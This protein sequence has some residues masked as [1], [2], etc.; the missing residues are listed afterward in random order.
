MT[1]LEQAIT[2]RARNELDPCFDSIARRQFLAMKVRFFVFH[3]IN[4]GLDERK[5]PWFCTGGNCYFTFPHI[6]RCSYCWDKEFEELEK[7]GEP[8]L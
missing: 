4:D 1:R 3:D 8:E 7:E 2:I 6:T 5:M